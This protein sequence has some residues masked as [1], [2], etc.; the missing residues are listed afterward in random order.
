M[1]R[2][3]RALT[4]A[5]VALIV[6]L[7]LAWLRSSDGA[8]P[9]VPVGLPPVV[10]APPGSAGRVSAGAQTRDARQPGRRNR[11][12]RPRIGQRGERGGRPRG[13]DRDADRAH[14][15]S[16]RD[17]PASA[18]GLDARGGGGGS[19]AAGGGG[20]AG[21]SGSSPAAPEFALG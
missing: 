9:A 10:V 17:P 15:R 7:A 16:R 18:P 6:L 12:E 8:T 19:V 2:R 4:A 1:P 14:A 11:G 21:A 20:G 5:T 13:R 3:Q